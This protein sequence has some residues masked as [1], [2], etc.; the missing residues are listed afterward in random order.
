MCQYVGTEQF[1]GAVAV[2]KMENDDKEISL[3]EL[4]KISS[5]VQKNVRES[6]DA[7][8]SVS[9]TDIFATVYNYASCYSMKNHNISFKGERELYDSYFLAG[10]LKS[11]RKALET[12]V[13]DALNKND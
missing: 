1:M 10:M 3:G 11:V 5:V 12:A 4:N 6:A 9:G 7:V 13:N 2:C 8:L